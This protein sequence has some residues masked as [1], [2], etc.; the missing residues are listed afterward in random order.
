M[1][2]LWMTDGQRIYQSAMD[3]FCNGAGRNKEK[4]KE[5]CSF[6]IESTQLQF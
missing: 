3:V 5:D 6:A 4:W 2:I 1:L